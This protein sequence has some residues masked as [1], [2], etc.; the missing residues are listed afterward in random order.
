MIPYIRSH[1]GPEFRFGAHLLIWL[2]T[3]LLL[4]IGWFL[5]LRVIDEDRTRTIVSSEKDL[6]NLGRLS[7][8]HAER[9]FYSAD[10]TLRLILQN[11]VSNAG[12][13]DLKVIAG[14]SFFDP[15]IL[16]QIGVIDA[17]GM[18]ELSNLPFNGPID[19]SD[20]EHF[21]VHL[22]SDSDALF[23]SHALLGRVS[24]KWSIQ[25]SRRITNK[26]GEFGGVVI[27]S[28]DP[29]YFTRFYTDLNLG[30]GS[31]AALYGLSGSLLARKTPSLETFDGNAASSPI[32]LR[33]AQGESIGTLT[34]RS[35]VDGIERT[36]HFRKLPSYPLLVTIGMA[37]KDVFANHEEMKSKILWQGA[38]ASFLLLALALISSWYVVSGRR[39]SAAQRQA[40]AQLQTIASRAPGVL[41]QFLRHPDGTSCFPFVSE[42]IRELYRCSPESVVGDSA[43][44]FSL[45]HPDDAGV[46][47]ES[48][49]VSFRTLQ[50]WEQEF[51][52]KFED[53]T[54]RWQS[55]KAIPQR[56]ADGSVL[57]HGFISDA[58]TQKRAQESLLTLSAAVEQSPV[59][60]V[61]TDTKGLIQYV[62]PM[63][64]E[65]TGYTR[66]EA[67]GKNPRILSS[68]EKSR[69][70]YSDMWALLLAGKI[71]AGEFHNRR[72]DGSL[73]WEKSTIAPIMDA[74]G[75][76]I[77][78]L[79]IK[80]NITDRKLAEVQLRIAATAFESEEGMFITDARGV[81]LRVNQA[82]SRITGYSAGEAIGNKPNLLS[83]G[84][85]EAAFYALMWQSISQVGSWQGE[86]WNRRKNG[87]IYPE[88]LT[89]SAVRDDQ[90]MLTH[91]VSTLADI[92]QRKAA[93]A[94]IELLA[95]HD[96]LTGLP[97]RRLLIDRL[98]Q[99]L[100]G[101]GRHHRNAALL[102]I[103]LDNFKYLNDTLGHDQGD[104][105]LQQAA[106][107]LNDC[108]RDGD[109]VARLG[110]DEFVVMLPDLSVSLSEATT[111]AEV[112]GEKILDALRQP[113]KFSQVTH[114][115]SASLGVTLFNENHH[116][117]NELLKRADL[118]LYKA[119]GAGRNTMRLFEP[120]MQAAMPICS[121]IETGLQQEL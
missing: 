97:N 55:G 9:T 26:N 102:F 14:Q 80:E 82:F 48:I 16:L 51:R 63:F 96:S 43:L 88:W 111:Q 101:S 46:V 61:I 21:K 104:L 7:Q 17:K 57:W 28:L 121:E 22:A 64:E 4:G 40:L 62:N 77:H 105:L 91:Y 114:Y 29:T 73:F 89:I 84:R 6:V 19:L 103:D 106:I 5:T 49:D 110:G 87:E 99:T 15:R 116:S 112:V 117:V 50:P 79:A 52:V 60:V 27:A 20:R 100:A 120:G 12:K 23:I 35:I 8:E 25:L 42:G 39:N 81:I 107:R 90:K 3:A 30:Q 93:E 115:S 83:S 66:A 95:F 92:T 94:E 69:S 108:V 119:K 37:S 58:T 41:Y 18:L 53:G 32:F 118:A 47:S 85:H 54:V 56:L 78:Y 76:P 24:G 33:V 98:Q 67:L 72:K 74:H 11:Y 65:V 86:I 75:V 71:W 59:S 109:T 44:V 45:I 13:I 38:I 113:Y 31:V 68:G 36:Y 10:Q 2:L 34:S 70:D 1:G